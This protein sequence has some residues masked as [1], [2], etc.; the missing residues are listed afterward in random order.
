MKEEKSF[1]EE[2]TGN[3]ATQG[4]SAALSAFAATPLAALLPVLTTALAQGR[5]QKRVENALI[6]INQILIEHESQLRNITDAQYK[7]INETILSILQT[8][9][10]RKI[11]YLKKTI[12]V[13]LKEE[14]VSISFAIPISRILR[15]ISARELQF[16]IDNFKYDRITFNRTPGEEHK[17]DKKNELVVEADSEQGALVSGLVSMG[18]IVAGSNSWDDIGRY[19][20]SPL[21]AKLLAVIG[22]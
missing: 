22:I 21:V 18:L 16:L 12:E 19:N 7:I 8:T 3:L 9:E 5:H 13:N 15:D 2:A 11:E 20:F 17:P 14:K 1:L 6:E 10:D 4:V